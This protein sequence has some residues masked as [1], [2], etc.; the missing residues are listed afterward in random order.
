MTASEVLQYFM[1]LIKINK[2]IAVYY[3]NLI[4][5]VYTKGTRIWRIEEFM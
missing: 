3:I 5:F 1:Q 2:A 4:Q